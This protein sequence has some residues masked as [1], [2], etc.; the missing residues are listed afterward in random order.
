MSKRRMIAAALLAASV[1]V[2]AGRAGAQT[3]GGFGAA[4]SHYDAADPATRA[5]FKPVIAA[6][7]T[8]QDSVQVT[9]S[10]DS[11]ATL[12]VYPVDGLYVPLPD[13]PAVPTVV[14]P[15]QSVGALDC[16]PNTLKVIVPVG[17]DPPISVAETDDAEIGELAVPDAGADSEIDGLAWLTE[18]GSSAF[19]DDTE[20]LF[21]S[22]L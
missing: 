1:L 17:E 21:E 6:G 12:I 3:A 22:P 20:L 14:P 5:Y 18:T 7:A 13:T 8:Y 11:P 19:P 9:N 10:G 15:E 16:G 4:P 2:V